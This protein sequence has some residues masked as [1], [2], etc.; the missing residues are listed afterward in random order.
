[1]RMWVLNLQKR[2][3]IGNLP[4]HVFLSDDLPNQVILSGDLPNHLFI[5]VRCYIATV[6][7]VCLQYKLKPIFNL[8][9]HLCPLSQV[10]FYTILTGILLTN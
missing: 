8:A 3:P 1:M 2:S 5:L 6:G 10:A 9:Y 7:S 4:N